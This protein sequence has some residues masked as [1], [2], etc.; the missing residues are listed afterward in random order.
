[1]T[2]MSRADDIVNLQQHLEVWVCYTW[3]IESFDLFHELTSK[4][5]NY[6]C[7]PYIFMIFY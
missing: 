4:C 1:M 7:D 5:V 3:L 2:R 6:P